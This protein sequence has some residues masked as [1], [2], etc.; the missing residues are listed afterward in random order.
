V[1]LIACANVANLTLARGEGRRREMAVR[2]ALG[3]RRGTLL[4]QMLTESA[5]VVCAAAAV[6]LLVASW[7][8]QLFPALLPPGASAVVLDVRIDMRL[9]LF[10]LLLAILASALVAIVP[11]WRGSKADITSGLKGAAVASAPTGRTVNLRDALVVAEI[12]LSGVVIVVA[13]LLLRSFAQGLAMDP[14]FDAAKNVATFYV[15]PGLKGYNN[16][17]TYRYLES[18]RRDAMTVPG[19]TRA[20]YGIRLP[21]QGNEAGWSASFN[22]PGHAPPA[23]KEAFDLR[24][25]MVG[26]GYFDVMGTRILVGR[27]I[28]EKDLPAG[29]PVAVISE[30]MARR[31]W[32]NDNP[33]GRRIRMG[34]SKPVDREIVGVAEDIR[35]GSLYEAAE[36]YVYVPFAQHQQGFALLLV[37]MQGDPNLMVPSVK[38]RIAAVDAAIPILRVSSFAE[39]MNLLLYED[40]RNAWIGFTVALLALTLGAIG[41]YGV[42]SLITARRTREMGIRLALGAGRRQLLQLLLGKGMALAGIGATLGII[43]GVAVGSLLQSQLHGIAP[44]DPLSVAAGTLVLL[45]A[46]LA[47]SF[48]PAWRAAHVDATAALRM[49]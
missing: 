13:G 30:S 37:E 18:A 22:V 11:A 33:I 28:E 15:V 43:G 24:Y 12:A 45:I 6:G 42:V 3:A 8:V 31:F 35:I 47:A 46:A 17:A 14:G 2:A 44:S 10:A 38:S 40:R 48:A 34:R 26:P 32:P 1:L 20:S 29:E 9:L 7:L 5:L 39:H 4:S 27:G 25:T 49:D 36:P 16:A 19:V 23:G 41:V 21:A